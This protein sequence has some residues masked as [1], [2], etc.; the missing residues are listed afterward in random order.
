MGTAVALLVDVVV[1]PETTATIRF[2]TCTIE[3]TVL[4]PVPALPNALRKVQRPA[5]LEK[6]PIHPEKEV[7]RPLHVTAGATAFAT[8]RRASSLLRGVV[9]TV[10]AGNVVLQ[11]I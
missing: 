6:T 5:E 4:E 1:V 2:P 10:A 8:G 9:M 7:H 11:R 3:S